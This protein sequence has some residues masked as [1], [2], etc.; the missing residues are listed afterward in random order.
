[1]YLSKIFP[2]REISPSVVETFILE[3]TL[4]SDF[5]KSGCAQFSFCSTEIFSICLQ[6]KAECDWRSV[7]F[8]FDPEAETLPATVKVT[9]EPEFRISVTKSALYQLA[10]GGAFPGSCI[11]TERNRSRIETL[12]RGEIIDLRYIPGFEGIWNFPGKD[13]KLTFTGVTELESFQLFLTIR[14]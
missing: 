10:R 2:C 14:S 5:A 3:P 4:D 11:S 6:K 13:K 8:S 1:M 7:T 9:G 12:D